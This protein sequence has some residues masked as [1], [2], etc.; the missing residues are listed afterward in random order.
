M[1]ALSK[2]AGYLKSISEVCNGATVRAQGRHAQRLNSA[3]SG[4]SPKWGAAEKFDRWRTFEVTSIRRCVTGGNT[5]S[6]HMSSE[7]ALIADLVES[8]D[9]HRTGGD[10]SSVLRI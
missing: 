5:R 3:D 1:A 4:R 10:R 2:R 6:E 7:I 9:R 8:A